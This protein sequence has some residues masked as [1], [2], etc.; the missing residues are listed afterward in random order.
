[1]HSLLAIASKGETLLHLLP[2]LAIVVGLSYDGKISF[3]W[4]TYSMDFYLFST[5]VRVLFAPPSN[6]NTVVLG[7]SKY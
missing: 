4:V 2:L 7:Y 3:T 6:C 5:H 1:M